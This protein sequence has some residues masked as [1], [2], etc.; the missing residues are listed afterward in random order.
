MNAAL[1][2]ERYHLFRYRSGRLGFRQRRGDP[3][4]FDEAANQV[5]QHRVTMLELAAEFGRSF[6]VSHKRTLADELAIFLGR[7]EQFRFEA[8]SQ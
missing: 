4:M 1:L 3:P 5:R 2:A 7:F 6:K 8:H